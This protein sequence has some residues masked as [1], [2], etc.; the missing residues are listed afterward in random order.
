[1]RQRIYLSG[2]ISN[3][4]DYMQKFTEADAYLRNQGYQVA[5][6]AELYRSLPQNVSYEELMSIDLHIMDIC[7][8]V[9]Q[10]EGWEES[11]GCNREYGYALAKDMIVMTMTEL[12]ETIQKRAE[13]KKGGE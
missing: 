5:N 11:K 9:I 7:D 8:T 3:D 13:G 6:P 1:M 4:P 10:L 12:K 2:P